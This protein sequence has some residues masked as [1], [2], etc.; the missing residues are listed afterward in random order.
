MAVAV[1]RAGKKLGDN[2]AHACGFDGFGSDCAAGGAAEIAAGND[3]IAGLHF[4]GEIGVGGFK[5]VLRHLGDG[6]EGDVGWRDEVGG[7]VVAELPTG[8]FENERCRHGFYAVTGLAVEVVWRT[9][10]A[11]ASRRRTAEAA[12]AR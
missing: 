2:D 5:D 11:V 1:K 12:S 7:D 10:R 9:A 3:D 8:A 6:A 4:L